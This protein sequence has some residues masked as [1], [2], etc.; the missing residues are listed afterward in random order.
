MNVSILPLPLILNYSHWKRENS[1][2][3]L[4]IISDGSL[5]LLF[6][7]EIINQ[8]RGKNFVFVSENCQKW[9]PFKNLN[10]LFFKY[11]DHS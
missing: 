4:R 10:F 6:L 9:C 3:V 1:K 7:P 5:Q 11:I 2:H 8:M